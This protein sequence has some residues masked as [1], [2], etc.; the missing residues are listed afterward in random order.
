LQLGAESLHG[1]VLHPKTVEAAARA[2]RT[3]SLPSWHAPPAGLLAPPGDL[4]A[5]QARDA[6]LFRLAQ[7]GG[8]FRL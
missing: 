6:F 2:A 7:L 4:N 1:G 3:S 5:Q 8:T